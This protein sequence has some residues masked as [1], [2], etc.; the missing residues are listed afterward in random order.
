MDMGQNAVKRVRDV[1]DWPHCVDRLL[2]ATMPDALEG[3]QPVWMR[4]R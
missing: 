3:R 4:P 2:A 1:L